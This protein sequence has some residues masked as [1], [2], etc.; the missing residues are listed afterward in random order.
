MNARL[1]RLMP[2]ALAAALAGCGTLPQPD[3]PP[4]APTL[5][6]TADDR[7][8]GAA[9][10]ATA[11]TEADRRWWNR[12][13]DPALAGWVERALANSPD[14]AIARERVVQAQALLRGASARRSPLIGAEA[15]VQA[16]SRRSAGERALDPSAA[17]TLDWDL[18]LWGGLQ[19]AE[20]SAAA[21]LLQAEDRAQ[22][23]RL[24]IAGLT[25]RAY[26]AWQE[27]ALDEQLLA[28][29]QSL[30]REV[31]RLVDVRVSAGLAPRL[32]RDRAQTETAT[33][34]ADAA[35]ARVRVRQAAAALQVLS[36]ERPQP[37]AA[38]DARLP[39]L[40]GGPTV[41][42]PIDLLR[43]RPDLRAAERGLAVAAA[44]LGVARADLYPRLRLPGAI[45]LT[46]AGLGGGVL[47]IVT[48]T[49]AAVLEVA[50]FDGGER[51]AGVE[52]ARSRVAEAGEVYRRTLLQAL[53][54]TEAALVAAE[55]TALRTTALQRGNAAA[56][57]ALEQSRTLYTNGLAG[58]LDVIEARRSALQTRRSLLRAQA[59]AARQAIAGFEA[60]G[61]IAPAEPG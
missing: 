53:Q 2:G 57:T 37:M 38:A 3:A 17:L 58:F 48:A 6:I 10:G 45:T 27:A 15:G 61:L 50:L 55:G 5:G 36:G 12:F 35:D 46:S 4:A 31:L 54:Q 19:Q 42:R 32:D 40:Q 22:A 43:L 44:D 9:A 52:A 14:A 18:D 16:R 25:A 26:V 33:L 20:Q 59:D 23:A 56:L 29:G 41:A 11:P 8:A 28:D 47:D 30:Q 51:S 13:N 24:S 34:E 7:F 21:A 49:L 1:R 39:V 60:M